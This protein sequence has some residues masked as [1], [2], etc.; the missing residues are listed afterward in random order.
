MIIDW[1]EYHFPAV[2]LSILPQ[3]PIRYNS[4]MDSQVEKFRPDY[5]ILGH[6]SK[7][8]TQDGNRPGGTALYSGILAQRMGLKVALVTSC[9]SLP[10]LE[11]LAGMHIVHFPAKRTTTFKNIYTPRGREQYIT[12]IGEELNFSLIPMSW[13]KTR[14]L[15]FG[16]I[17]REIILPDEFPA[18]V[19]G[20]IVYSLQGWLRNW[21]DK[22][23][24]FPVEFN[25]EIFPIEPKSVGFLSIEDLAFDISRL[26]H[27]KK[28]FPVLVLTK[29][30]DG[31]EIYHGDEMIRIPAEPVE[32]ID[33]TGAGDIF[34]AGFMIYW[35]IRGK[36]IQE[37]GL[38]AN[39][40]AAIS[41]SRP[42]LE[43]IPT[44]A[45]IHKI[46]QN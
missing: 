23:A 40:L 3:N 32:E 19:E 29:G 5:L 9:A 11:D 8:L 31:V 1:Q 37:A 45:E 41:I 43:G 4:P 30:K 34:A 36:S 33:P 12:E 26:D 44:I 38:L 13:L 20:A 7:D 14:I 10:D 25:P 18:A 16:S 39:Q 15:H 35:V 42:G 24:V 28:A 17:A 2:F 6:I 46:E 22:G 27:I 21:D